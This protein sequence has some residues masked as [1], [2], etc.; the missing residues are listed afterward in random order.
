[1]PLGEE[2][3]AYALDILSGDAVVRSFRPM[4]RAIYASADEIADFGAH[5]ASLQ[6]RVAQ[7]SDWSGRALRRSRP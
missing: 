4:R 2:S 7:L 5:P 6:V 3:E 1:M